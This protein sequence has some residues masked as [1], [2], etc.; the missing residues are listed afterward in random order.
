MIYNLKDV[1]IHNQQTEVQESKE[2]FRKLQ[3]L[4]SKEAHEVSESQIREGRTSTRTKALGL[5]P[6]GLWFSNF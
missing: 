3:L 4:E 6:P 1:R 5:D 2:V